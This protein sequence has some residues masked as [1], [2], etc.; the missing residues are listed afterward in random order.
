MSSMV[1][2]RHRVTKLYAAPYN[3]DPALW[4]AARPADACE[5]YPEDLRRVAIARGCQPSDLETV[6]LDAKE[7]HDPAR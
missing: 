7:P 3:A 5:F 6:T 1:Y 4:W 2:I